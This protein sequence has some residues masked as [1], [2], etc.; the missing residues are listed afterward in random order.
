MNRTNPLLRTAIRMALGLP[1]IATIQMPAQASET[2]TRDARLEEIVVTATRRESSAQDIPYNLS[3]RSGESLERNGITDISGLMRSIPGV[4]YV[5]PGPRGGG[6]NS[7]VFIR[8][9]N[10]NS[11]VGTSVSQNG[12]VAPVSSYIGDTPLFANLY[13]ADISRVEVLRGPQGTLYGSGSLGGTVRYIFNEVDFSATTFK[14]DATGSMTKE[15]GDPNWSTTAV[16]NLPL[17]DAM[18][19]RASVGRIE[20]AG[21]I[22]AG[23]LHT[24]DASGVPVLADPTD[25]VNSPPVFRSVEDVNESQ[26]TFARLTFSAALSETITADLSYHY[27]G[28]EA[29]MTQGDNPI[30]SGLGNTF[31]NLEPYDRDVSVAAL[32]VEADLGFAT[33]ASS[34]STAENESLGYR[35]ATGG[36]IGAGFWSFYDG[37]PRENILGE[38]S[39]SEEKFVQEFRLTSNTAGSVDW[40]VGAYFADESLNVLSMDSLMGWSA[41]HEA[42]GYCAMGF[43]TA[44]TPSDLNYTFDRTFDVEDKAVFG[45]VTVSLSEAWQVTAGIRAFS[46]D[47]SNVLDQTLPMCGSFCSTDGIDPAGRSGETLSR[48]FNDQIFRFN[49]SYDLNESHLIYFNYAEGFR[50]GGA[51]AVPTTGVFGEDPVFLSFEPDLTTNYEVGLKGN[52]GG[53]LR[54]SS[55]I[56]YID[57]EAVQIDT[58][59]PNGGF[60]A[61]VNGDD[62]KSQG[63]ELEAQGS[64]SENVLLSFSY[65]F[66]DASLTNDF[67]VGAIQGF[68][69][70]QLPATPKHTASL[71]IEYFTRPSFLPGYDMGFHLSG[72]YRGDAYNALNS[73]SPDFRT[74]DGFSYFDGSISLAGESISARL[75]VNNIGNTRGVTGTRTS[76]RVTTDGAFDLITR[77]RTIG[78]SVTYS[79]R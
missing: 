8:G 56:F 34:T 62:A 50:R 79:Y 32:E 30:V 57:W 16:I 12:T 41:W 63:I 59:T 5:D 72:F 2:G 36:Y 74:I 29:L 77:P 47:V 73:S 64:L 15:A 37:S 24:L 40:I 52:L 26:M 28:D 69:G 22:D 48:S 18:G 44:N 76:A 20:D 55:S 7:T 1:T 14:L 68:N 11:S 6:S 46:I 39:T 42:C 3:A 75:F 31:R 60:P 33:L 53:Y 71:G 58:G 70:D 38:V 4:A 23:G 61:I 25:V 78:L 10:A 19:I 27:Q 43:P 45:E 21:F 9:I 17:S 51:N 13:L 49:T 35:D 54:Y 67:S 65:S 66:V